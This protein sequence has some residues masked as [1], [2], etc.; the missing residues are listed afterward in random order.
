MK[1]IS[2]FH[3][4]YDGAGS[5]DLDPVPVYKRH[6]EE[7]S[8]PNIFEKKNNLYN[9]DRISMKSHYTI[10]HIYS[11]VETGIIGFCG[12]VY[13]YIL[14]ERYPEGDLTHR[15][16]FSFNYDGLKFKRLLFPEK[17]KWGLYPRQ[18]EKYFENWL[19][20]IPKLDFIFEKYNIPAFRVMDINS[21]SR[22]M[23]RIELNPKLAD[24]YFYKVKDPYTAYQEIRVYLGKELA[25]DREVDVPTGD[26]KV[27]AESKGYDKWSF[28]REPGKKKRGRNG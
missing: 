17:D 18:R 5:G 14:K 3:D 9:A 19:Q 22:N 11:R 21:D 12:T 15:M 27:L 25:R 10:K 13:P 2:K 28:R 20:N 16:G 7:V 23:I 6:T 1:I 8:E 4:Y 24:F 26:D